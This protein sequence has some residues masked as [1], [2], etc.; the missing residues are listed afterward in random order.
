[1]VARCAVAWSVGGLQGIT[2]VYRRVV[3][4]TKSVTV[5]TGGPSTALEQAGDPARRVAQHP[6]RRDAPPTIFFQRGL[7]VEPDAPGA[8]AL[9]GAEPRLQLAFEVLRK[10]ID[11]NDSEAPVSECLER[12]AF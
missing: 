4:I 9:V 3:L 11:L 7:V 6:S 8:S 2:R 10:C 12:D 1:M 5:A